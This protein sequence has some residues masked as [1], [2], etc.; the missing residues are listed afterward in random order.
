MAEALSGDGE[1]CFEQ[2][3]LAEFDAIRLGRMRFDDAIGVEKSTSPRS[4]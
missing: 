2:P 4:K 1:Q 3:L